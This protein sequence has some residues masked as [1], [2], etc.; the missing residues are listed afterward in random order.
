MWGNTQNEVCLSP[1][2]LNNLPEPL[3]HVLHRNDSSNVNHKCAQFS[4]YSLGKYCE[5]GTLNMRKIM[6]LE[7]WKLV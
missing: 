7:F 6:P 2:I 5:N 3:K 1:L 4:V